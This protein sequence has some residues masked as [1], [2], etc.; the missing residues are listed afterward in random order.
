MDINQTSDGSIC[1]SGTKDELDMAVVWARSRL[2]C[3]FGPAEG[4]KR[5][6]TIPAMGVLLAWRAATLNAPEC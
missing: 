4:E 6:K 3:V 2:H 1:V 5:F